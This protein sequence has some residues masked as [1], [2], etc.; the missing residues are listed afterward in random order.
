ML[1]IPQ[2]RAGGDALLLDFERFCGITNPAR[3]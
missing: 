2:H 1:V 3:S